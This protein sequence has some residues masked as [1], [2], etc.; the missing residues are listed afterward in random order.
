[1]SST[2]NY[3]IAIATVDGLF[4]NNNQDIYL[5]DKLLGVIH[6]LNE[7]PYQFTATK[8]I[9]NDRFIL[10]YSSQALS[11]PDLVKV[12]EIVVSSNQQVVSITSRNETIAKVTVFDILGR[13]IYDNSQISDVIHTIENLQTQQTL[14][15]KIVLENGVIVNKKVIVR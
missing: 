8:G 7:S 9:I 4:A 1:V 10:R 12:N 5:E 15:L 13:K 2:G 14:L 3:S 6:L 11:N